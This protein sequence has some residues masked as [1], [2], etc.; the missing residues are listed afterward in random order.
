MI[1][2]FMLPLLSQGRFGVAVSHQSDPDGQKHGYKLYRPRQR[3]LDAHSF[4]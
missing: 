4:V 2:G 1:A 3:C